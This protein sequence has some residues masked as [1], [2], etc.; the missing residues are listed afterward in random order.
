M[1][2]PA[3]LVSVA[4]VAFAFVVA[5]QLGAAPRGVPLPGFSHVRVE[6]AP[7]VTTLIHTDPS[8]VG[9]VFLPGLT[10][11]ADTYLDVVAPIVARTGATISLVDVPFN[12]A[13]M[14][15]DR[16]TEAL[17]GIDADVR[18]LAGHSMGGIVALELATDE[19]DL[20]VDGIL[21][22]ASP[23][24][25]DVDL[26]DRN[27]D[28]LSVVA[29]LDEVIPAEAIVAGTGRLPADAELVT[30]AAM[31][32]AQFGDYGAVRPG[33]ARPDADVQAELADIVS[34]WLER[35]AASR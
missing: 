12:V 16:A 11:E 2:R 10:I 31:S 22:L 8:G 1:N 26:R 30:I 3:L 25:P 7:P 32:H 28:V 19:P 21:A 27:V 23:A 13:T 24:S 33:G 6:Y 5:G 29:E 18:V 15:R 4:T 34:A 9:V 20:P 14:G 35:L 17:Q